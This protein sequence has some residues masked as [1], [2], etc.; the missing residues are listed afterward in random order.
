MTCAGDTI[1]L[2]V[3]TIL[4]YFAGKRRVLYPPLIYTSIWLAD[5]ALFWIA[6]IEVNK[7]HSITWW[8]ILLGAAAFSAGGWLAKFLP[9]KLFKTRLRTFAHATASPVG[10]IALLS[11]SVAAIPIL[12]HDILSRG[13]GGGF[14]QAF[15]AARDSYVTM[16]TEGQSESSLLSN[17][18]LYATLVSVICLIEKLDWIFWVSFATALA[19]S[20]ETTGRTFV[21]MLFAALTAVQLIK[22]NQDNFR[23]LL[24]VGGI[25][26]LAF[27]AIFIALVFL[28]K[29]VSYFSS[30]G[31]VLSNFVLAY[32]IMPIPALDYVLTHSAEFAH[33]PHHTFGIVTK[34]FELLGYSVSAPP[35]LD[36]YVWVPLPTN[37]YTIYKFFFTDFGFCGALVAI[38]AIGLLQTIVYR[39][40]TGGDKIAMLLCGLLAYS[41]LM[42][43]FDDTYSGSGLFLLFKAAFVATVYWGVLNRFSLGIRL[44]RLRFGILLNGHGRST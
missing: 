40:A 13:G 3:L 1:L 22:S 43:I 7:V 31:A 17:L 6:P 26:I 2:A 33:A 10:R 14:F 34:V 24:K 9:Q 38:L 41:V 16:A 32:V 4:N 21:L 36:A 35:N 44:P 11:L 23:G 8:M 42:S 25:T 19:C 5:C 18:P 20:I 28:N 27:S 12:L 37:V 15:Q 39:R 30:T 29:D